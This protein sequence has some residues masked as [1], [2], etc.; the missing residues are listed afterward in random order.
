M[1]ATLPAPILDYWT[2]TQ[3]DTP[4]AESICQRLAQ[5][6]VPVVGS[7]AADDLAAAAMALAPQ[8]GLAS[9]AVVGDP[10][11]AHL[12]LVAE[13]ARRSLAFRLR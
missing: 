13:V 2:T 6:E 4:D 11:I 12:R 5:M 10:P 1:T 7:T 8:L 9:G 3:D